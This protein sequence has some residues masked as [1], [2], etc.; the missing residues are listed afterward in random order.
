MERKEFN[1]KYQIYSDGLETLKLTA[2]F[3]ALLLEEEFGVVL[4]WDIW[5]WE[6]A[7]ACKEDAG[8]V[9]WEDFEEADELSCGITLVMSE[10]PG[11]LVWSGVAWELRASLLSKFFLFATLFLVTYKE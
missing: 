9:L 4:R 5:P 1:S 11:S 8:W 10:D 2:S 7:S 6:A 3:L